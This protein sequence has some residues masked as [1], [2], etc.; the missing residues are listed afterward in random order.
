MP[1]QRFCRTLS[2]LFV[3]L[4]AA[5]ARAVPVANN[6]SYSTPEDVMLQT[7][8]GSLFSATFD[9]ANLVS[10]TW[11]Y[12]DRIKNAQN[13][14]TLDNYPTDAGSRDWKALDFQVA[15]STIG[16][17]GSSTLPVQAGTI[18]GFTGGNVVLT[19]VSPDG[20]TP[21]NVT[22]YLF[23]RAFSA[24]AA[25][26][27]TANW[28]LR[29][30]TDDGAIYY[31]NGQEIY[32]LDMD[33]A[34]FLP[35]GALSTITG[36]TN[37]NE[38]TYTDAPLDLSGKLVAG[39]NVLAVEVHQTHGGGTFN[40][41]DVGIDVQILPAGGVTQGFAYVDDPFGTAA[42][43]YADGVQQAAGG[44][45]GTGGL[46]VDVGNRPPLNG[47][48]RQAS[49]GWSL[50]F[51]LATAATVR[52]SVRHRLQL[53]GALE[54]NESG[55][56][57][58]EVDGIRHGTGGNSYLVR[59]FGQDNAVNV[60]DNGW[61]TSTVDVA[62]VAGNHALTLGVYSNSTSV[63]G[64]HVTLNLDDISAT[65]L[66]GGNSVLTNDT[67]GAISATLVAPTT[68]GALNLQSNGH[69]IYTPNANYNGPDSFTY[70]AGDG[71]A[72]SNVATANLTITPVNDPPVG[73]PESYSTER[74]VTLNVPAVTGVLANDSDI[75]TP[76]ANLTAALAA[77]AANGMVTLNANGSFAY[78]PSAGYTGADSFSYRASDGALQSN[79]VTVN[80]TVTGQSPPI[81]VADGYT[82]VRN[83]VLDVTATGAST[84]TEDAVP[85][86]APGWRYLDNGSDQGTAWRAIGFIDTSWK[87]GAAELGY[88][89]G[90]EATVVDDNPTPG[91]NA[92][93]TDKDITTYFR[94]TFIV[95]D[96]HRVTSVAVS[97][98][99]DD[100]GVVYI[101]GTRVLIT[102]GLNPDPALDTPS[103]VSAENVTQT[104]TLSV[105][106]S[107]LVE[108]ANS[109][110]VEIHQQTQGS[111]DISMDCRVRLTKTIYAGVLSNDTDQE[112]DPLTAA[113]VSNVA[114]GFLTLN[115]NGT[116]TYIPAAGYTGSDSFV[117]RANDGFA[118]SA[119]TTASLTVIVGPNQPPV[120]FADGYNATEDTPLNVSAP[121]V[122]QNDSDGEGDSFTA[123]VVTG[124]SPVAAGSLMLNSNGSFA[125]NPALNFAGPASFTYRARDA[126][127][128][129]SAPQTVTLNVSNVNDAPLA[130]NDFY[131]TDPGAALNVSAAGV[132]AND[133]D[134]DAA[135]LSAALVT[136]LA[137]G[138]AGSLTL[139]SDGAFNF[140]PAVGF[141][142]TA[143]FTYR[144]NDG[145][146]NSNTATVTL[147]INARPVASNDGYNA[148][149]DIPVTVNAPGVLA[150][151]TDPEND[152]LSAVLASA[153]APG[154]GTVNLN[155]TGSFTFTPT[156]NFNGAAAFTYRAND[157]AR[158]SLTAAT[159]TINV[160]PVNDAP[161]VVADSYI[162]GTDQTVVVPAAMGVLVNDSDIEGTAL[163]AVPVS[164]T[165]HGN[166]TLQSDGSF[167]Y[168][169]N[170]GFTGDDTF[171]YS[172]SDGAMASTP[173]T[174]TIKVGLD[175]EWIVINEI[176]FHPLTDNDAE[177]YIELYNTG[178][179]PL[180]LGGWRFDKGVDF[181][182][183]SVTVPSG[184]Y[185]VVAADIA[186]FN[187]AYGAVPV[188][189]GGWTG[190]LANG[191]E[192]VRLQYPNSSVADGYSTA[193]EVDFSDE[194]D[195]A[196][197][198]AF[199][200]TETG[201]EWE[202]RADGFG[203]SLELIAPAL[204]NDNGQNWTKR[205]I[206]AA[207]NQRTPGGPNT[208]LA[209]NPALNSAPLISAV[210]HSPVI[211]QP[212]Q[213]VNVTAG[214]SDEIATGVTGRV[215]YRTWT[216]NQNAAPGDFLQLDMADDGL[217]GDGLANDGEFG[218]TLPAQ[219]V[220]VIVEFY[221]QALDVGGRSQT[222]PGPTTNSGVQGA[223]CLYQV[224]DESWNG[225][226]PIYRMIAT[227]RDQY[228]FDVARWNSN[229]NAA[230]NVTFVSKQGDDVD[231]RYGS[232]V[233]VRGAGSRGRNPRNWRLS[234]PGD[235]KFNG[236]TQ[237]NINVWYSFLQY[238][239][240]QL[241]K[242]AN[243]P[244]EGST[245]VQVRLNR[246]NYATN[247]G[248]SYGMYVHM[249]PIGDD[250]YTDENFSYDS[251]G[252]VYKK[253]RPHQ[254]FTYRADGVGAPGVAGYLADGWSK[255]SNTGENNWA[256]LHQLMAALTAPN[257][258]MAQLD[259]VM[260]VDQWARVFAFTT[261]INDSETNLSNG[262]SD[263]FGLY[264][265]VADPRAKLLAH[266]YDT[267]FGLGDTTTATDDT[268]YQVIVNGAG[269]SHLTN[270]E[271]I[272]ALTG[273]FS[274]PV[275]NQR[276]K[277]QLA[278]LLGTVFAPANFDPIVDATLADWGGPATTMPGSVREAIKSFNSSRRS[279]ILGQ[280]G[281]SFSATCSL[282][283]SNG[284]YTT[285]TANVTGLSGTTDPATTRKVLVNGIAV[286]LD[287]YNGGVAGSGAWTA[288]NAVAL[289]PG[290]NQV[291]VQALGLND[292]VLGSQTFTI[293]YDDGNMQNVSAIS[294]N[295]VWTAAGGPY[296]VTASLTIDNET[297]SIEP[298][299]TVYLNSGVSLEVSGTGRILAEG[300]EHARIRLARRPGQVAGW[301]WI[302]ISGASQ[303]SRLSYVDIDGAGNDLAIALENARAYFSHL[304]FFNII[305]Q[306]FEGYE[307]SFVFEDSNFPALAGT[308][309]VRGWGIPAAGY[310]IFRR[311]VFGV[312]SGP[313]DA[314]EFTGGQRPNAILQVLDNTFLGAGDDLLDLRGADAH[315]EG[316]VFLAAHQSTA[317]ADTANAISAGRDDFS[318]SDVTV[319]RNLFH[320]CDH[321]ILVTDGSSAVATNNT[322][323]NLNNG[324]SA[325][326]SSAAAFNFH[327]PGN[328]SVTPGAGGAFNGN[329]V[330]DSPLEFQNAGSATSAITA[331]LNML[332]DTLPAPVSG[333]GNLFTDPR[334]VDTSGVT[335]SNIRA[336]F[337]LQPGSPPSD[338]G[339][340]GLDRGAL[341]PPGASI[342][343][344]PFTVTPSTSAT[345]IIGGPGI[346]H[347]K[348]SLDGAPFSAAE[349][350][351]STSL[352]L[353][354]LAAGTHRVRVIGK[355]SA[356]VWQA[357]SEATLSRTWT[358]NAAAGSAILNEILAFNLNAHPN[359]G[360]RPDYIEL[361]NLSASPVNLNGWRIS[362]EPV[363]ATNP[364][365]VLT[366]V[367]IPGN[368]FLLLY[369]DSATSE[370]GIHLGF[371]LDNDGEGCYLYNSSGFLVDS[372]EFGPQVSDFS[373]GRRPY[374]FTWALNNPTPGAA[375]V[376][377]PLALSAALKI[378][379][380][381]GSN[382]F[383]IDDDFLELYNPASSPV[384]LGGLKL[385]DDIQNPNAHVIAPLSFA[386]A[387]GFVRFIAD[388]NADQGP[389]HLSWSISKL[390]DV[391]QL[392][393]ADNSL[394]DHVISGP[395]APDVSQGRTLDGGGGFSFFSLP[396]PGYSNATDLTEPTALLD[397]LR[398]TELMYDPTGGSNAPEYVEL[399]NI[400]AGLTF[401]LGGV[402]FS[403]G[404]DYTF[405]AGTMLAP[406]QFIV[407]TS[408][409][410][411]FQ[412]RHGFPAFGAYVGK[413][414]NSG[415]RVRLEVGG[416][417]LGILDFVYSNA[418]YSIANG[419]GG[420]I[421]II[422]PLA[423]R[424]TWSE[425][426]S[427]RAT[428]PNP[429][430]AGVFSVYAG[431]DQ[432]IALPGGASLEA[433]VTFGAVDPGTVSRSWTK[434]SGPGAVGFSSPTTEATNA[435]FGLPG[436]YVLRFSATSGA[437]TVFDTL[438]IRVFE[439]Y[440]A[441]ASRLLMSVDPAVIGMDRDPDRDGRL[442][443]LEYNSGTHPA[444]PGV[445]GN[446]MATI[447][448]GLLTLSYQLSSTAL[449]NCIVEVSD[450]LIVWSNSTVVTSMTADNGT[451]QTWFAYDSRPVSAGL[452]RYIRL[453]FISF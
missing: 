115:S 307:S 382:D 46:F 429:G 143:T 446:G 128:A 272:Q 2:F 210:K 264:F 371:Q 340:N 177:E 366:G 287:N 70:R 362:D 76:H 160:A 66:S 149:E 345:L 35:A 79:L 349:T 230:I 213:P 395:L 53:Q 412:T 224:D 274:D 42:P 259:A 31:L 197:R 32:R 133:S 194:G 261:I 380:W 358:V 73:T 57:I 453:R 217:H 245:P 323:V 39:N 357:E 427:W 211:P 246:T 209:A 100:A 279:S 334:L 452:R 163:T 77:G 413:F 123:E 12:L 421:E 423:P 63:I 219:A 41:S 24:T 352:A 117:Y 436:I 94:K 369:A 258:T 69:F 3:A 5:G 309:L 6:D 394:I 225:R 145:V 208:D 16:P 87:V 36:T 18:D 257:Y 166:L 438:Q 236:Q 144:A 260:D 253:V 365:T 304:N 353:A 56:V 204:S 277:A 136:G 33:P 137:P 431:D 375:N 418:W 282:G 437:Q 400:S 298:G 450:D 360:T 207:G 351:V 135:I 445:T 126:Q 288:G 58:L 229:S 25:E 305:G 109:I 344:E 111:S 378:N 414:D 306:Y 359:N 118:N 82:L 348:S 435:S 112:N 308:T 13:G 49:G 255:Q 192:T 333:A 45:N 64:E 101:N 342:S 92:A 22:T 262:S 386:P 121:G 59:R 180:N 354:G 311:N 241:M 29:T 302:I 172:A 420:A 392:R 290:I 179:A 397:N 303:E 220:G 72:L 391:M 346:T 396:T 415:E 214:F 296:R 385:T 105:P 84:V 38:S 191:G 251:A 165:S 428:V 374:D 215:F 226:Q 216:A 398:I 23:R 387:G 347:Y 80:L 44:F 164:G 316:N 289:E 37:G 292:A 355:N 424:P 417:Q 283:Q 124:L 439:T 411:G 4:L 110:A 383:I 116:F 281:G 402:R 189:L 315:I 151:D 152:P 336:L 99:H 153:P 314:L 139:E 276:Y 8:G 330:F 376:L 114:H 367:S 409:A 410:S 235:H 86:L 83:S 419:G 74:G 132:L 188:L 247:T 107:A 181:T 267:I 212:G 242:C 146:A 318:G 350:P 451:L 370:P 254:N 103:S 372:V 147:R 384:A 96:L 270:G 326:G 297:L 201:W 335:A 313:G 40:S 11:L 65:L 280:I 232:S 223:N 68:H 363:S 381:L 161:T 278:D 228:D 324:G 440:S 377:A 404:I 425:E 27:A 131:S 275:I 271:V 198:R 221:L 205:E 200:D 339:P 130:A 341:V 233:R 269:S 176:M 416:Y 310:A 140:V 320:D 405:P 10:G 90:D 61:Q 399:R 263:D 171:T 407:I 237:A 448:N 50:S 162:T 434:D 379:E 34:N 91:Y 142:G 52:F 14:Q 183:P 190:S 47:G 150:N 125:F 167:S 393:G 285:T 185:L 299:T 338:T 432:S 95:T 199:T 141:S 113:L 104:A 174:V 122:L 48:L 15:S 444:V 26:A 203:D 102:V 175:P 388:G 182:F 252:N 321:A 138:S 441:W 301:G 202:L 93:D 169:P 331:N 19:G 231:V 286:A 401:D 170:P 408:N 51:N 449:S 361:R 9:A 60:V 134:A 195:W 244:H 239:G 97:L 343:G 129:V 43:D 337:A 81:G 85:F 28:N 295:T 155:A 426:E 406:R 1:L 447:S 158:D 389:Q 265:G 17:W 430:S 250:T 154:H 368:G 329:I 55:E 71:V 148:S 89:D 67:G 206:A 273:Y 168:S 234:F 248:A 293:V 78:V 243:L 319:V 291:V 156:A 317:G 328:A 184:G 127:S 54:T 442:N 238:L 284:Y 20:I 422:N 7:Q 30:L 332:P 227:G 173:V 193:D 62:L 256:D 294:G 390:R 119:N 364:G 222:Y 356:G 300:S 249:Q 157:G 98:R 75:D 108:G 327:E 312:A 433:L 120:V 178:P 21:Y 240:A 325:V 443:L 268:I 322:V 159:V 88:G 218:A 403:N 373:I 196:L 186:S 266:D 187:A 106:G